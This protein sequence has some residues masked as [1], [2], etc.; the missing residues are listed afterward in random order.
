MTVDG[1]VHVG[2]QN[3]QHFTID[4]TINGGALSLSTPVISNGITWSWDLE[5]VE[6]NL[7]NELNADYALEQAYSLD[8]TLEAAYQAQV[9]EVQS[10][11]SEYTDSNGVVDQNPM[12]YY[13]TVGD[14]WCQSSNI[15]VTAE[16]LTGSSAGALDAP[17]NAAITIINNSPAYL[18]LGEMTIPTG[19]GGNLFFNGA[20]PTSLSG[21]TALNYGQQ[22]AG[23]MAVQTSADSQ[24]PS[25]TVTGTF[26]DQPGQTTPLPSIDIDGDITN[27]DG[28]VTVTNQGDINSNA[29]IQAKTPSLQSIQG[30]FSQT[31]TSSIDNIG[32]DPVSI[33]Q[34]ATTECAAW[35]WEYPANTNVNTGNEALNAL[36]D[37]VATMYNTIIG[38]YV[39][40]AEN[41]TPTQNI[42]AGKNVYISARN[43]NIDGLV[44]SGIANQSLY[45]D[46]TNIPAQIASD[47]A[48]YSFETA[49]GEN[50]DP[51]FTLDT[52]S[53]IPPIT[54]RLFITSRPIRSSWTT[55]P[56]PA[57]SW[58]SPATSS[59]PA[60]AR[61]RRSTATGTSTSTTR[62]ATPWRS[63]AWTPGR[64]RPASSRSTTPPTSCRRPSPAGEPNTCP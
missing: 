41:Q 35:E 26:V 23:A 40:Q 30:N 24:A 16:V 34:S 58:S 25:I 11:L 64:A 29:N 4:G 48:D 39:S 12:V 60:R 9:D 56:F 13:V 46:S 5:S 31:Y 32:S 43:L 55:S 63:E 3:V 50:P 38:V 1:T 15:H 62:A 22:S 7:I 52:T 8:P 44:E 33:W 6:Q 10:E 54:F 17:G 51:V 45:L 20:A 19:A 2:I 37:T 42:V 49:W 57:G 14:I 36:L 59:A 27:L 47:A 53:G 28:S 21:I 61:S 18:R